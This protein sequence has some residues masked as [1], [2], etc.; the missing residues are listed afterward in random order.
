M[1]ATFLTKIVIAA[2]VLIILVLITGKRILHYKIY[3]AVFLIVFF[4]DNFLMVF[5]IQYRSLQL[6][7]VHTW[8]GFLICNWSGKLYSI[9][10]TLTLLYFTRKML[11]WDE[12]GLTL[13][14]KMGSLLP[15][16]ILILFLAGWATLVGVSSPKGGFDAKTLVYLAIMPALNEE[17]VYRGCLLGILDRLMP[18]RVNLLGAWIGWGA[19][20]TA[21]L[22]SLLHGFW[23]NNNLSI[24][25]DV[26]ALRNSF[27]SGFVFAWLRERTGSLVMPVF[28][29]GVEDFLF[30]LPRMV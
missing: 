25:F 18:A 7:P 16:A 17:L 14:Q 21:I 13:H 5:T 15:S 24:H 1:T 30:F 28:A 23:F 20:V 19:F 3:L 26:I 4:A 10:F 6:I 8:E 9:I 11:T 27:I 2:F 29:H 12:I 22:F